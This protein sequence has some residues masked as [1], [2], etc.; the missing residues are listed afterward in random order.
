MQRH[1]RYCLKLFQAADRLITIEKVVDPQFSIPA[2]MIPCQ[3]GFTCAA[4]Q[5]DV[6][7]AGARP[8]DT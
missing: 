4:G 2:R 5:L 7:P 1:M 3:D 8:T 6:G